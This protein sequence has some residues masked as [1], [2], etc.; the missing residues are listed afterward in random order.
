MGMCG[1]DKVRRSAAFRRRNPIRE[2]NPFRALCKCCR[3]CMVESGCKTIPYEKGTETIE[4]HTQ[5]T[6]A[7]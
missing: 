3:M 5:E 6:P 2:E 1:D 7:G 4:A